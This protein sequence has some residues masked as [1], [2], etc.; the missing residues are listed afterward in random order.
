MTAPQDLP[1]SGDGLAPPRPSALPRPALW[2]EPPPGVAPRAYRGQEEDTADVPVRTPG[3]MRATWGSVAVM[4][5][6][7]VL[8]GVAAVLRTWSP[9]VLGLLLI[10]AGAAAAGKLRIL[11]DVSVGQSPR[12]P[13]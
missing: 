7:I 11:T 12:G 10:G 5:I 13:G 6:G 9:A 4:L 3:R 2:P 8:L 1:D